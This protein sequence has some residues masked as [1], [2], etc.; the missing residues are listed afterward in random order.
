[1]KIVKSM[2]PIALSISI[3]IMSIARRIIL[4]KRIINRWISY[5]LILTFSSGIMTLFI[6]V[7]SLS[8]NEKSKTNKTR[9]I[10]IPLTLFIFLVP[11]ISPSNIKESIKI[12]SSQTPIMVI[13]IILLVTI[14]SIVKQRFHPNQTTSSNF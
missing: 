12:F 5:V 8:P 2:N 3:L 4:F 9:G 1:M 6:Y 13:T 14:F 7:S 11:N 10:F